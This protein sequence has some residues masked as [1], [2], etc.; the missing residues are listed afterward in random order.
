MANNG[1]RN[2]RNGKKSGRILGDWIDGY[3]DYTS[4]QESPSAFHT[5]VALSVLGNVLG[6][7]CWVNRGYYKLYPN[8]YVVLVGA[9][10]RV[11]KTTAIH[12]GYKLFMEAFP[13]ATAVS[14]KTTL[15]AMISMFVEDFKAR[16]VSGGYIVSDEFGVLLGKGPDS[17]KIM[18]LL[19]K[20]YDCPDR[21]DYRT[22]MRGKEIA[23]NVYCNI[24]AGTTPQWMQDSMPAHAVGGGFTSRIIFVFQ[25]KPEKLVPFPEVDESMVKLRH[26]LVIDLKTINEIEGEFKLTDEARAWYEEWY[27]RVFKPETTPHPSLDGYFG[28]KHDTVLKLGVLFAA[29]KGNNR[30]IEERE[31]SLALKTLNKAERMLPHTIKLMQM[32]QSGEEMQKVHSAISRRKEVDFRT[33][34]RSLSYCMT[35]VR[36]NEVIGDLISVGSIKE[37]VSKGKRCFRMLVEDF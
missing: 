15:E 2:G 14:Q 9:S 26:K 13:D 25:R 22:I 8:L 17:A 7:K 18:E 36:L 10:A 3:L 23:N 6:R 31:L 30:V 29:S 33:L 19:T 4:E 16:G 37:F 20:W 12:M 32:T 28:R 1:K 5:W 21:F 35:A 34:H 27:M 11:R 24:L